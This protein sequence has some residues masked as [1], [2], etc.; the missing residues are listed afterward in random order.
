MT[1]DPNKE[2]EYSRPLCKLNIAIECK[3]GKKEN[4]PG[5]ETCGWNPEVEERRIKELYGED[6][7]PTEFPGTAYLYSDDEEYY[8]INV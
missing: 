3:H 7:D 5:C 2:Y 8:A 6:E 1:P 4:Y